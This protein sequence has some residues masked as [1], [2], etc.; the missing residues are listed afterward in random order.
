MKNLSITTKSLMAPLF[1]CC[2]MLVIVAVFYNSFRTSQS[3]YDESGEATAMYSIIEEIQLSVNAVQALLSRTSVRIHT[4][5]SLDETGSL[6]T[7][8]NEYL[9]QI[10]TRLTLLEPDLS[11]S[12]AALMQELRASMAAYKQ[13][14][15]IVVGIL[16]EE[17]YEAVTVLSETYEV[18][19][20]LANVIQAAEEHYEELENDLHSQSLDSQQQALMQVI[21]VSVTAL[22]TSL[23]AAVVCGHAISTPIR[24]LAR[25][26]ASMAEGDYNVKV[27]HTD[28][29]DE[30]G[31]MAST[32]EHLQ[33]KLEE[34]DRLAKNSQMAANNSRIRQA[35]GSA[36]TNLVVADN[37][38]QSIFVNEGMRQLLSQVSDALPDSVCHALS[39]VDAEPFNLTQLPVEGQRWDLAELSEMDTCEFN[40][41]G[42]RLRQ[43]ITPVMDADNNR[44]GLV[45]EWT[46]LSE[47]VE[48]E[49]QSQAASAREL[50]Q[51]EEIKRGAEELL[52]LVGAALKGDLTQQVV[53]DGEGA[54]SQI[55]VALDSLFENLS[56]SISAISNNAAQ[57]N[58]SS[59][60]I[61]ELN[62]VMNDSAAAA[63]TQIS[64]VSGASVELS[65]HVSQISVLVADMND[66]ISEVSSHSTQATA[67]AG[68][69]VSI[70][71]STD[72]LVRQLSDSSVGIGAVVKVITSIAEQTNLLALNATI[73]AA[74][75]GE[76]GKGFAVVANEVKEL[77][78]ETAKATEDISKRI[79]AIQRDSDGAVTAIGEISEIISQINQLQDQISTGVTKQKHAV[80]HINRSTGEADVRTTAIMGNLSQ[81]SASS[82]ET[83]DGTVKAL[84]AARTLK[85]M[86]ASMNELA[87]RFRIRTAREERARKAA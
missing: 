28:Q 9:E 57:L 83:L 3:R 38:G 52:R 77:A 79:S 73:E 75:A 67:V 21:V 76:S 35:L 18:F 22:L 6:V 13:N 17:P 61:T 33:L 7:T 36:N 69:A 31:T 11:V 87:S 62:Q 81:V 14:L 23:L 54:M 32:V 86:S 48:R 20:Q 27:S 78:K 63:S 39:E 26:V 49:R 45:F 59:G 37:E 51:A 8:S 42:L 29:R 84:E 40:L 1:A 66:S 68:K 10:E 70:T 85:S 15:D 34:A 74:R 16:K 53:I 24:S 47:Q 58:A 2:M 4:D 12:D 65:D 55:G 44:N 80:E 82:S 30:V 46:D 5:M 60:E 64:Q 50:A 71:Q 41:Q 56:G 72:A 25:V 43:T 19:D